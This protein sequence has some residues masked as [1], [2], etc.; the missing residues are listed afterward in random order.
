MADAVASWYDNVY[1][2]VVRT[3]REHAILKDFPRRTEADLYLWIADHHY[4]LNEQ[5]EEIDLAQAALDFAKHYS[6]RI[7]KKLLRGVKQA[8]TDFLEGNGMLPI[9]GTMASEPHHDD[10]ERGDEK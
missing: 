1:T 6:E 3:I 2:P 10:Q 9:E 4:F 8:V 5:G 7:D